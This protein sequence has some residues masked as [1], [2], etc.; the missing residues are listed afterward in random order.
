MNLKTGYRFQN[1]QTTASNFEYVSEYRNLLDLFTVAIQIN[2]WRKLLNSCV[3]E[4]VLDASEKDTLYRR[5]PHDTLFKNL[6]NHFK[7]TLLRRKTTKYSCFQASWAVPPFLASLEQKKHPLQK[8][9]N[10]S[11]N[12]TTSPTMK[13]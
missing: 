1:P 7:T 10:K 3:P 4:N 9:K 12:I 11:L 13:K 8:I 5:V 6:L 2:G